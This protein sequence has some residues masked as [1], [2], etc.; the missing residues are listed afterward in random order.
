MLG[1]GIN[2]MAGEAEVQCRIRR[3]L[4]Q[5]RDGGT[6]KRVLFCVLA[7]EAGDSAPIQ[8]E[9]TFMLLSTLMREGIVRFFLD[10]LILLFF[11]GKCRF[12]VT[13]DNA[14]QS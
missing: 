8:P 2:H 13:E 4:M 11:S 12:I 6:N 14:D 7:G 10:D 1:G 9:I 5:N 3:D